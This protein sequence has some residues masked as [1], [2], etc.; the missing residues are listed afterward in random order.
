MRRLFSAMAIVGMVMVSFTALSAGPSNAATTNK[1]TSSA[2]YFAKES[3]T[4]VGV[5]VINCNRKESLIRVSGAIARYNASG[6]NVAQRYHTS[7]CSGLSRCSTTINLKDVS[8]SNHYTLGFDTSSNA[9]AV[10]PSVSSLGK[11]YCPAMKC[12]SKT[13]SRH[14]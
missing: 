14:F 9:T 13:L 7:E 8:G 4:I 3:S 12:G 5:L 1:C 6:A 11:I 2:E 10:W